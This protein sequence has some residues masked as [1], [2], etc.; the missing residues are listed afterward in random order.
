MLGIGRAALVAA[1]C[2]VLPVVQAGPAFAART[3]IVTP[4]TGLID[5]QSVTIDGT[6]FTPS[7]AV[8][9]CQAFENVEPGQPYC[10]GP[11]ERVFASGSGEFSVPYTVRRLVFFPGL[12]RTVDCAVEQCAIGAFEE[13][14]PFTADFAPISFV[15]EQVSENVRP[16]KGKVSGTTVATIGTP[17]SGSS[18]GTLKA[19]HLGRGN[20]DF[21]WT[22]VAIGNVNR[23]TGT[24]SFVVS[25]GDTLSGIVSGTG[26][27]FDPVIGSSGAFNFTIIIGAGTGR[28]A[29]ASGTIRA[30]GTTK[31]TSIGATTFT[32]ADAGSLSGSLSY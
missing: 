6:G 27:I 3:L 29:D 7:G 10:G 9:Y 26:P 18:N 1:T 17:N 8:L 22:G 14:P 4:S 5:G 30:T 24:I 20:Y 32:T 28:F 16:F 21:D 12:G 19:S 31:L 23:I 11:V 13:T 25:N 2:L 15:R